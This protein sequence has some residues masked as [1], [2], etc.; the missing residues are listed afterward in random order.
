MQH[1]SPNRIR[2]RTFERGVGET[3]SCGSAACAAASIGI[4]N[5]SLTSPVEVSMP[6]GKLTIEWEGEGT[7]LWMEGPTSWM[8]EGQ[9]N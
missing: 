2:L 7:P 8:S 5:K 4:R 6:G 3:Q 1:N 9:I